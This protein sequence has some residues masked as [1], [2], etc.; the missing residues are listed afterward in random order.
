MSTPS[1]PPGAADQT[2]PTCPR[3][4]DR[5]SYVRC[6]RCGRPACPECS[7]QA[8]VGVQCVDCVR[9]AQRTAPV[10]RTALGAPLRTGRPVVT[11]TIIALCL[12]SYVL[13]LSVDGWTGRLAFSP[14]TGELEPWRFVTAAFLHSTQIFHVALNMYAL[15][16]VGPYLENLLGRAR[17]ISLYLL[18]AIGG[19]VAVVLL[20]DPLSASWFTGT[21]GASGAVFGLFGAIF[22]VMRRMGQEARGMLV[23]IGLNLVVGFVVPNISWQGHLGGL[24][25]GAVLGAAYAFAPRERRTLVSIVA[26][27]AVAVLLVGAVLLRYS[28]V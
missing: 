24:V 22:V 17:F 25:T 1:T 18:S 9:E 4:P 15:W 23:I 20:A 12:I 13:Q 14:F 19:H 10:H 8:S 11:Y 28:Q 5:V 6:Q 21:V 2:V 26:T 16:I 3:H 27:V 7:V